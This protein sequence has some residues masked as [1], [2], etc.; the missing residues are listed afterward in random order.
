[1]SARSVADAIRDREM[2][3]KMENHTGELRVQPQQDQGADKAQVSFTEQK[4]RKLEQQI[5]FLEA[6]IRHIVY[7]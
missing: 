1:M 7:R 6:I 4:I 2:E 3:R 5:E